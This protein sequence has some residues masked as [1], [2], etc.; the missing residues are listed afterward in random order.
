[1]IACHWLVVKLQIFTES[2]HFISKQVW[3]RSSDSHGSW[4]SVFVC[5]RLPCLGM[6]E[7]LNFW[8]EPLIFLGGKTKIKSLDIFQRK[9]PVPEISFSILPLLTSDILSSFQKCTG[10][11]ALSFGVQLIYHCLR[12]FSEAFQ[13]MLCISERKKDIK[14]VIIGWRSFLCRLSL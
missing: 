4:V 2:L 13:L 5:Q 12:I 9:D 10:F 3:Y 11:S 14:I 6:T 8:D 7:R 1:M